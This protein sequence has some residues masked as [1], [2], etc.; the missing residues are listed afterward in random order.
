MSLELARYVDQQAAWPTSGRHILAQY[1]ASTIVVYQAYRPSIAEWTLAHQRFGGGGWSFGR[2]SWIK[3]N[4]LWMMF[5]CGWATKEGQERVLAIRLRRD[6]FD[7]YVR[8]GVAS[9]FDPRTHVDRD[10]WQAAMRAS[11]VRIQWDPDHDPKGHPVERRAIQI[12]LRGPALQGFDGTALA[13]VEDITPLVVR[14]RHIA[15]DRSRWAELETPRERL[16]EAARG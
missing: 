4:F 12:G 6:A 15:A 7:G 5:R 3:P 8:E 11:D 1:D 9:T 16:Y 10:A 13:G 14:M 2:M